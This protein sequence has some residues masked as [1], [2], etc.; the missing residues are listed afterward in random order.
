MNPFILKVTQT[1]LILKLKPTIV[2]NNLIHQA[3]INTHYKKNTS[4]NNNLLPP[5]HNKIYIYIYI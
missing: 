4:T 1:P 5:S 2:C 3:E